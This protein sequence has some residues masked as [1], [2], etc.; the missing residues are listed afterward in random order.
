MRPLL[1]CSVQLQGSL[2]LNTSPISEK[3]PWGRSRRWSFYRKT[4]T[5]IN[6]KLN[7]PIWPMSSPPMSSTMRYNWILC[8]VDFVDMYPK[9]DNM[10][11]TIQ[12]PWLY[13]SMR[14]DISTFTCFLKTSRLYQPFKP[15][16][17]TNCHGLLESHV[18]NETHQSI[19]TKTMH[20]T[21]P[22]TQ[23]KKC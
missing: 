3:H 1:F 4:L 21:Q 5:S 7:P 14:N 9:G 18:R 20:R 8:L 16:V 10:V 19:K 17:P 13:D 22:K 15:S 2:Y 23:K 6:E 11:I 12:E